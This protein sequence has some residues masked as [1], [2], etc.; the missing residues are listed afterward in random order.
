MSSEIS[1]NYGAQ[2]GKIKLKKNMHLL[3][4]EINIFLNFDYVLMATTF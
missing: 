1:V 2:K 3:F 4:Y